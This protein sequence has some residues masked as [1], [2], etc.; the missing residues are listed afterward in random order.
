MERFEVLGWPAGE[1]LRC[2]R[3]IEL[4]ERLGTPEARKLLERLGQGSPEAWL[5]QEAKASLGR[6]G[7]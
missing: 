7:K 5:T 1:T 3:A 6:L 2:L 4:L